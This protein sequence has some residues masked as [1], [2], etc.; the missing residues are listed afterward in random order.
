MRKYFIVKAFLLTIMIIALNS[1]VTIRENRLMGDVIGFSDDV[2]TSFKKINNTMYTDPYNLLSSNGRSNMDAFIRNIP[3]GQNTVGYYALDIALDRVKYVRNKIMHKDPETKYYIILLTDGLDNGS[4][5]AAQNHHK[6]FYKDI[7]SYIKKLDKK[8]S[9]IMGPKN[10]QD[11]LQIYPILFTAGDLEKMRTSNN[12]DDATF[13]KYVMSMMEGYRGAS[14]G[15]E[16]PKPI[17]GDNLDNLVKAFEEQFAIQGFEFLIPKG[18]LNKRIRMTMEDLSGNKVS[19]EGTFAKKGM[20]FVF[21][22]IKFGEG[23]VSESVPSGGMIKSKNQS[24]K[25][26]LLSVFMID[27]LKLNGKPF[28]INT[29]VNTIEQQFMD[30]GFL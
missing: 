12:M 22:D 24:E 26:S 9:L 13:N 15:V 7:D 8:K 20:N 4:V 14:A 2:Q 21:K 30:Y 19:I 28:K 6:G 10:K 11:Y 16:T 25:G 23:L 17:Y 3:D 27:N 1:C 29:D 5:V 18:Y